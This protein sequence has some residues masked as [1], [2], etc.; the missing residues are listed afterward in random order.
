MI[1]CFEFSRPFGDSLHRQGNQRRKGKNRGG[2]EKIIHRESICV[3][4]YFT[5]F[6]GVKL[7]YFLI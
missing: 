1:L 4:E 7:K 5:Y 6:C 3:C 2:E